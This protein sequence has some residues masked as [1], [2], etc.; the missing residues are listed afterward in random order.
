[1]FFFESRILKQGRDLV[2]HGGPACGH[3]G[4]GAAAGIEAVE[5]GR[6]GDGFDPD[7][8]LRAPATDQIGQ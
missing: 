8:A 6:L 1:M 7:V 2:A 5:R 3:S 4:R